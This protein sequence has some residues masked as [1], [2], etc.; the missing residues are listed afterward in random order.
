METYI[1]PDDTAEMVSLFIRKV[2]IGRDH[3]V[4]NYQSPMPK[5]D[6]THFLKAKRPGTTS[7]LYPS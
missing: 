4:I 2:T 3:A 7:R 6:F 5:L 1:D